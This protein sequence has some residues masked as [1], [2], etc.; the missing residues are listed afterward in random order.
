MSINIADAVGVPLTVFGSWVTEVPADAVPENI[1]PDNQDVAYTPGGV[2]SR[3]ALQSVYAT[4]FPA[5]GVSDFV[6]TTV[7]MKSFKTPTGDIKNLTFDSNGVLWVEDLTNSPGTYTQLLQSTPGSFCKSITAFGREYIAISDGLHGTDIPWQYDGTYL[8]R[9]T[10]DG[11]GAPPTVTNLALPAFSMAPLAVVSYAITS[12]AT[13]GLV[14]PRQPI[15]APNRPAPPAPPPY[16]SAIT[17]TMA[18][19]VT[20]SLGQYVSISGNTNSNFNI[21]VAIT[22]ISGNI[23]TAYFYSTT[24]QS[25]TGGTA[26][27]SAI[28]L[29]RASNAVTAQSSAA[30][31][32]QVGNQVQ[33]TNTPASVVGGSVSS[34]VIN[35]ENLA[36]IAVVTTSSAHGLS[37]G[38]NVTIT[39]VSASSV[40]TISTAVLSGG[41]TTITT[42]AAHGQVPGSQVQ[43]AGVST[44][45]FNGSFTVA[46]VPSPTQLVYEQTDAD[47]TGTG[48]TVS[49]IWPIPD[50]TPTP[51]YFQVQSA[52]TPTT[53]QVQVLS[54]DGSWSTGT[55]SFAWN[56][57]FYVT[58]ILSA[59]EFQYQQYGP[60]LTTTSTGTITPFGQIAP[61]LHLCQV[62]FLTRQGAITEPSPP[63][64]FLAEGGQYVTVSNIP[65]GPPNI[66]GRILAFTGAQPNVPGELPPFFYIP[67]TPQLEGQIVGTATQINDNTTTSVTLDFSDPTLYAAL[68][69]SIPGNMLA[70]Q[71]VLDGALG[72]SAYGSRLLTIGQRN[73]VNNLLNM[74]FDGGFQPLPQQANQYEFLG[75]S[76]FPIGANVAAVLA[77]SSSNPYG[78]RYGYGW[79]TVCADSSSGNGLISQP[80]Y[81]DAY[82][83]PI[84]TG[85][86][87]YTYRTWV[88]VSL[89]P[90]YAQATI[91]ASFY[92]PTAGTLASVTIS[93]TLSQL[94]FTSYGAYQGWVE[95]TFNAKTPDAIPADTVLQISTGNSLG[96]SVL[97]V[98]DEMS[99]IYTDTPYTDTLAYGSYVNN[100]EGMDG[101]SGQYGPDD[102]TA[103]IMDQAV[104]RDTLYLITQDPSGRL[105]E[106]NGSTT[107][108]PSGW[109][110]SEVA[111]N[112]G[113][114]SAFGLTHSQA[115][116]TAASGGDD[117]MAW[118]SEGGAMIF[119]G[120]LPAKISQEI[121]PNWYDPTKSNTAVQINMQAAT[122]IWGVNDPVQRLLM[123]GLPIGTAVAPNQIY[124]LN[125]RNLNNASAIENSPPFHPS[126]SGK[127][128]ATDNSRKWTH[129]YIL[130]NNAAR[131]YRES[132]ELSLTLC[133][134]NGQALGAAS[135]YG[136]T[137]ILN[138]A[139][140]IDDDYGVFD[141]YYITY[142]FL[143]AQAA[144]ALQLI[145]RLMI[146]YWSMFVS[147]SGNFTATPYVDN[148]SNPWPLSITRTMSASPNF[149]MEGGGGYAQGNR[150]AMKV[151]CSPATSG[152]GSN[153]SLSHMMLWFK[154]ARFGVRGA[155]Q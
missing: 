112:C 64:T 10:Q 68:G 5:G 8:D 143:D 15:P 37:P 111:A 2:G 139:L 83:D 39:G 34:I 116:N 137:Y 65:T 140:N 89:G 21:A 51:T 105:H 113:T 14:I 142:F 25:G 151:S 53:F 24:A 96:S 50:D 94:F 93:P 145:G 54:G 132:G 90:P 119:G 150:I 97:V 92:S 114:L 45:A 60:N 124:V 146:A 40:A 109:G 123:F 85:N 73:V 125:Y 95:G 81:E 80:A 38:D 133:G 12:I 149:E 41:T 130:A 32:L 49:L 30:N 43:I 47:T 46:I 102:D 61:G 58:A 144:Q 100:P 26:G 4:P 128:I 72:F 104:L 118:P 99:L 138:P 42:T 148:L 153:F 56:G 66:V 16:Y 17:V 20:F 91:T 75:W 27:T 48:G 19:A 36:G 101:V 103:K 44:A 152:Q 18:A 67:S 76:P 1:S 147:G 62:L 35:N 77:A 134:G 107:S 122:C 135:G 87:L 31:S 11:P 13:S 106:T 155:A 71:I 79:R 33:V 117:W 141:A 28:T 82:G 3:P 120:G 98:L 57:I 74:G 22:G 63:I 59:T 55:V 7:Y 110:I 121:Q 129:W 78:C 108:E 84:L 52:P 9:V 23:F 136:N 70:N 127:L 86:T 6:P 69:I 115:D 131:T 29:S 126:F 154:K 88:S